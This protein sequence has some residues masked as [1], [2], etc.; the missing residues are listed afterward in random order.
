[1]RAKRKL[2]EFGMYVKKKLLDLGIEQRD[3]IKEVGM[4]ETYLIDIIYGGRTADEM[5][6]RIIDTLNRLETEMLNR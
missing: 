6:K 3:L 4:S 5:K 2:T 1:M